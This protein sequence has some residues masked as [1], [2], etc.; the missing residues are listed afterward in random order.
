VTV[1]SG[2]EIER[3]LRASAAAGKDEIFRDGTWTEKRLRN[4]AYDLRIARDLLIL[5]DGTRYWEG[6]PEGRTARSRP[7][8]LKPEQVAFVSTVEELC[9]P[10]DLAGNLAPRFRRALEGVMV[11]GGMLVDPGYEGRLHF[12]LANIGSEPFEIRP[13]ETSVAALQILPVENYSTKARKIFTSDDLLTELF[14]PAARESLPP[15]A[16]FPRVKK[17]R[18]KMR[19]V[20]GRLDDQGIELD[21]TKRSTDQLVVFGMFLIAI[22]LFTVAIAALIEAL[23]SGSTSKAA[24]AL[25]NAD[26]STGLSHDGMT[27][28]IVLLVVVF[29]FCVATMGSAFYLLRSRRTKNRSEESVDAT[30]QG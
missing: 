14:D 26:L 19:L 3:R 22:T 9:M 13:G 25:G 2:D 11:I 10:P 15:L 8:Q 27:A 21:S 18:R 16:F 17:L 24:E 29:L 4:A 23:A 20:E 28:V 30:E 6:S 5:P 7:F 12:Q 1:L